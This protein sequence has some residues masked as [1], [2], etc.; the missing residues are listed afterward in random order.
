M[1]RAD[2]ALIADVDLCLD[3]IDICLALGGRKALC[4][5]HDVKNAKPLQ[6][7]PKISQC[8]YAIHAIHKI[9]TGHGQPQN[10]RGY[11]TRRK[12]GSRGRFS[13][14]NEDE[15]GWRTFTARLL[16][17]LITMTATTPRR[18]NSTGT[19]IGHRER[20]MIRIMIPPIRN[21]YD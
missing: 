19:F 20:V 12:R 4:P 15:S 21:V 8:R 14:Q 6:R 9:W 11:M 3:C 16:S 1:H 18:V 13:V 7:G 2:S 10:S 5:T 17:S